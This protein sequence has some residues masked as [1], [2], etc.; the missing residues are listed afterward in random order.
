MDAE[1]R[2]QAELEHHMAAQKQLIGEF[3]AMK[4]EF[5]VFYASIQGDED[6]GPGAITGVSSGFVS[7]LFDDDRDG[8]S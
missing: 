1:R 2:S 7:G 8:V 3:D 5:E 6:T 4:S